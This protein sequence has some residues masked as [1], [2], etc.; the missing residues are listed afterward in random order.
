MLIVLASLPRSRLP[1]SPR[2]CW[3]FFYAYDTQDLSFAFSHLLV[4]CAFAVGMG[5]NN[6]VPPPRSAAEL[7][8]EEKCHPSALRRTPEVSDTRVDALGVVV[9]RR[10]RP[11][12]VSNTGVD[13][14]AQWELQ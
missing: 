2:S 7:G 5:I 13:A 8:R 14:W 9:L 1:P 4:V 12:E 3:R 11:S 10:I 6:E